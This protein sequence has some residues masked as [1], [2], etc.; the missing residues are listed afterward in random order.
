MSDYD[1]VVVG[2][3]SAGCVLAARLSEDPSVRVLLVEA[4]GRDKSMFVHFPAGV[5]KLISPEKIAPENWGYYTVPQKHMNGRELYWPRGRVLGGS[6]SINGMVYIRGHESDY[7]RWA[8]KGA[9]GW[10]WSDVLP[11]FQKSEDSER[12][13]TDYHGAGGPLHT[14]KRSLDHPLLRAFLKAGEQ[15]GLPL[16]DDFN[17]PQ[18]EGVGRYDSTTNNGK[19]WSTAAAYL[20][21]AKQ[22]ANLDILTDA[23]V[24]RVLFS[25]KRATAIG[26]RKD[27]KSEIAS[28][29]EII[30]AGGAVNS[31]QTLMLSGIGPA[32]HIKSHG[33]DVIHDLPAVGENL[34]DHLDLLCQWTIDQPISLNKNAK[35]SNQLKA[36][37]SW[38]LKKSG[39]GSYIPTSAGAFLSTREGLAAP[40]IQL[41]LLPGISNP[42][43]RGGLDGT[44]HGFVLHICQL[45]PESRGTIRLASHDPAVHPLIDP[46]YLSAPEDLEVLLA[47]LEMTREFGRQPAFQAYGAKEVWPGEGVQDKAALTEKIRNWGETIYHPVGTCRMGSDADAVVDVDCKVKGVAGLRVVDASVMPTLISGNTNAPT[48]MIAEKV[49]DA[50]L[51]DRKMALAA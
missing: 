30:L 19:R 1:Y 49:A 11:Y 24:E 34:Q 42:H 7:D 33:L 13:A 6:S 37:G 10:G 47:G 44:L 2:A 41:H 4:G 39:T 38:L 21:P 22:R 12:G 17:G 32:D 28:G 18:F 48:I 15:M 20:E 23:A 5:G 14:S 45:R 46:N 29:R 35:L 25:G 43:G 50:I 8:Q 27:G 16:T 51:L 36:L 40:D 31:P 26:Y 3:G 9:T